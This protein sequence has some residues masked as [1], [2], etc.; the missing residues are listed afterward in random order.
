VGLSGY[1]RL[2]TGN[3]V[4][5][6]SRESRNGCAPLTVSRLSLSFFLARMP[7]EPGTRAV[8]A[9][10][11]RRGQREEYIQTSKMALL[12]VLISSLRR[13]YAR[14]TLQPAAVG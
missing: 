3:G 13:R 9:P 2:F 7:A 14:L 1:A 11:T 12:F 4:D 5:V 6:W 10:F 8:T